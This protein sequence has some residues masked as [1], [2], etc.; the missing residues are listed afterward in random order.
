VLSVRCPKALWLQKLKI[1]WYHASLCKKDVL[2]IM[3]LQTM[4][5]QWTI[6]WKLQMNSNKVSYTKK[7]YRML[8]QLIFNGLLTIMKAFELLK[9]KT[10]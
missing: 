4:A 2:T 3:Y 6:M 1:Q 9:A 8:M 10:L 7:D 5:L